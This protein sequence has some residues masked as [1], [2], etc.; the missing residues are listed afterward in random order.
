GETLPP[1]APRAVDHEVVA[2]HQ[3]GI[4]LARVA[5]L[6]LGAAILGS[7][8]GG[9]M[10]SGT[11]RAAEVWSVKTAGNQITISRLDGEQATV[12]LDVAQPLNATGEQRF[13]SF[14]DAQRYINTIAQPT[15]NQA[16]ATAAAS[17]ADNK[18]SEAVAEVTVKQGDTLKRLA[19]QY[20]VP[21]E[22]LMS[23]N[24]TIQRWPA[25]RI[26]QKIFVPASPGTTPVNMSSPVAAPSVQ[27]V[28]GNS[29]PN[30]TEVTV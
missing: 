28:T 6:V 24:P 13:S 30:T 17:Q 12:T 29:S 26:G 5:L 7:L 23:L 2:E 25:I 9:W 19:D 16:P 14:A 21:P 1:D 20:K 3:P 27:P 15:S 10:Q 11:K 22:K 8:I 18:P 4:S